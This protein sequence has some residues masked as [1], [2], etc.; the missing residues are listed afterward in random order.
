MWKKT[1]A[2]LIVLFLLVIFSTLGYLIFDNDNCHSTNDELK[3]ELYKARQEIKKLR[4]EKLD[5]INIC[6]K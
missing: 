6:N 4:Q 3:S 1:K 2:I 5:A